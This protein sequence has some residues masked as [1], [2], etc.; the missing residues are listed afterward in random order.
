M[1]FSKYFF[2]NW[3]LKCKSYVTLGCWDDVKKCKLCRIE[4]VDLC[5]QHIAYHIGMILAECWLPFYDT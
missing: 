2:E 3:D 4:S 1:F 5:G